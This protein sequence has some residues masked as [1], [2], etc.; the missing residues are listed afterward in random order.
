MNAR[1]LSRFCK[2]AVF[3][4]KHLAASVAR[5][6][7]ASFG[8]GFFA[9]PGSRKVR[10]LASEQSVTLFCFRLLGSHA[11]KPSLPKFFFGG[12]GADVL[13]CGRMQVKVPLGMMLAWRQALK[14]FNAIVELVS[15]D[16]VN[17]LSGGKTLKPAHS[18]GSVQTHLSSKG[19][20]TVN[21]NNRQVRV[22]F[23]QRFPASGH[24]VQMVHGSVLDAV[25]KYA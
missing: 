23:A 21:A 11:S 7:K 9:M 4:P 12:V 5:V 10:S 1:R 8:L 13:S 19:G 22:P 15:V 17:V 25:Y 3:D 16:V 18:H 2:G 20:V 6:F 24:G 14:V